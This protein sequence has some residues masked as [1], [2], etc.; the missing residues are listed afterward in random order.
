[1]YKFGDIYF[2]KLP[3]QINSRVQQGYRPVLVVSNDKNNYYSTIL[4]IVPITS[5]QTKHHL[6]THVELDGFGLIKPSTALCEQI[7][8]IDKHRMGDKIGEIDDPIVFDSLQRAMMVQ[9]NMAS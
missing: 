9:L 5:S 4:S 6:P 1:M 3:I 8:P 7:M 2:A